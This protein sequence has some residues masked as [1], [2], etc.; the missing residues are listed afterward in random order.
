MGRRVILLL[1]ILAGGFGAAAETLDMATFTGPPGWQREVSPQGFVTF[2]IV[3]PD[4]SFAQIS[5]FGSVASVG[6]ADRDF[7]VA[8]KAL[9][10]DSTG[11]A[12]PANR[13]RQTTAQGF[14]TVIGAAPVT[15]QGVTAVKLVTTITANARVVAVL[16]QTNA[17]DLLAAMDGFVNGI[18]LGAPSAAAQA[19]PGPAAPPGSLEGWSFDA[20]PGWKTNRTA[21]AIVLTDGQCTLALLPFRPAGPSLEKDAD[22]V[23]AEAFRGQGWA[24][25]NN[26]GGPYAKMSKGTAPDG[27]EYFQ[28]R[29]YLNRGDRMNN[30]RQ[31]MMGLVFIARVGAQDAVIVG[32]R[33]GD[34]EHALVQVAT[35]T[36]Y[37]LDEYKSTD[38]P[39]IFHSLKF[40]DWKPSNDVVAKALLGKWHA[41]GITAAVDYAFAPNGRYAT[42]AGWAQYNRID[43]QTVL[44]TTHGV[45]GNGKWKLDGATLT[46]TPD[47]GAAEVY[48]V[49]IQSDSEFGVWNEALYL[50]AKDYELRLNR[51]K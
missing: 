50:L 19:P 39:R 3:R 17:Q 30:T 47:K 48:R 18:R 35:N 4:K 1:A 14:P 24:V 8:W 7:D 29:A 41:P 26:A 11:V 27:W 6:D 43:A 33:P 5:V 28:A 16:A 12:K 2:T 20:P 37:C 49:R 13:T 38:W 22:A 46:L 21:G 44:M 15:Q 40:K 25:F 9:V 51:E 36:P 10:A 23:F 45:F 32:T 42:S 31:D 34:E